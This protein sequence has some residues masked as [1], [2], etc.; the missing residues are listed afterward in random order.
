[1]S[2]GW[3]ARARRLL[4]GR[5]PTRELGLVALREASF[6]LP[7]DPELARERAAEA[8]VLGREL[9]DVDLEMTATALGGLALV[10]AF[11]FH[12]L[13]A[14]RPLLDIRLYRNGRF[15]AASATT[16]LLAGALFGGMILMPLYWQQIRGESVV[17][18]GLLTAPMGVGMALVMP[19]V[20]RLTDRVGGG[21]QGNLPAKTKFG[22]DFNAIQDATN[23]LPAAGG[24]TPVRSC[25][26]GETSRR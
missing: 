25:A 24:T 13:R 19:L 16:F 22:S 21:P 20:G 5:G 17:D 6:A 2:D 10:T 9:D 4:D 7:A 14:E 18:T 26:A 1:M 23:P 8:E 15:T 12:A 3:L 11:V